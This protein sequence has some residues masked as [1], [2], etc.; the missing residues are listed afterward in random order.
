MPIDFG[1]YGL[2]YNKSMLK[3]AGLSEPPKT[4]DDLL[5]ACDRLKAHNIIP[6]AYG[7]RDGYSTDNW[8]T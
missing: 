3:Q 6:I 8:A 7:D 4:F 1:S 2:F 5:A